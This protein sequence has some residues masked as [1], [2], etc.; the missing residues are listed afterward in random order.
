MSKIEQLISEIELYLDS[1]KPQAFSGGKMIVVEKDVIDEMLVEL[2]MQTP[3]EIKRYQKIISNKDAI[4]ADAKTKADAIIED[5][6]RQT[7]QIVSEHEILAQAH[8]QAN[9]LYEE[10]QAH[11]QAIVNQ[12]VE[13]ANI[14]R[15]GAVAYVDEQ[16]SMLQNIIGG[17]IDTT[18]TRYDSFMSQM[19]E[20]ME[21]VT[22][23][24]K[25]LQGSAGSGETT[26][27]AAAEPVKPDA[28]DIDLSRG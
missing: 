28:Y 11:A 8:A 4:L 25:Q 5:A 24:R 16:L 19:Q 20:H 18:R 7:D 13:D 22:S 21:V 17:A 9:Q 23:N 1:C 10:A 12:A 3:E 26:A 15:S 6:K 14:M 2:R 27:P